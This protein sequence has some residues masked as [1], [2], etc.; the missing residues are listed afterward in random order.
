[1]NSRRHFILTLVPAAAS[2]TLLGSAGTAL[3]QPAH[4]DENDATAKALGYLHD[5]TKVDAA[6][7][8]TYAKGKVCSNCQLYQGKA[9]DAWGVCPI[10]GGKQVNANGWCSAWAKKAG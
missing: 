8:P 5:A 3:A 9:G 7:Y 10:L 1:M 4:A 2:A 6:K